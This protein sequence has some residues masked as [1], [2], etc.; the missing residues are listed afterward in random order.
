V[1]EAV[2]YHQFVSYLIL[3]VERVYV[4]LNGDQVDEVAQAAQYLN[5]NLQYNYL[6]EDDNRSQEENSAHYVNGVEVHGP[7]LPH[8]ETGVEVIELDS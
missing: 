1:I 8:Y 6:V 5:R 4:R 7:A 2:K 3:V